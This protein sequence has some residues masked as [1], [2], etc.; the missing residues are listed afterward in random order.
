M[1]LLKKPWLHFIV[2][3]VALYW[4]QGRLFPEPLPV[5]GPLSAARVDAL[6]QQWIASVGRMPTEAQMAQMIQAELDRDMLFQQALDLELHLY[7]TVVYQR[8]LRNMQFLQLAEGKSDQEVYEQA[9]ELRL[10]LGDEVV[11][12]RLIQVMEQ[13]MLAANPPAEPGE[14]AIREEFIARREELWRPPR[15][16]IEHLY[17]NREREPE[18]PE[19]IAA[20]TEQGM[21]AEEALAM[22]SPFL[23]GYR[24]MEQT[25]EQLARQFGTEFVRNLEQAHPQAGQWL[26]PIRSTY[27]L[28]YVFVLA[29]EPPRDATLEEVRT[30]L[31]RD[32][33][34]RARA[35]A[36]RE[37]IAQLRREYEVRT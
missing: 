16:S 6:Q 23:P 29:V 14:E 26:G 31:V 19:V 21:G 7:D 22:S 24:F 32:L 1:T 30:Q 33:Q 27:G 28:H 4:L 8:L 18:V 34:S 2:L 36:L 15:Y 5:I 25:P 12:R 37:S 17:F 10:H 3:G 13:L 20:I 35:S 11:K 9:L